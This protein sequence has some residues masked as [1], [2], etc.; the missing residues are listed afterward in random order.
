MGKCKTIV[1]K[2]IKERAIPCRGAVNTCIKKN[3]SAAN[4]RCEATINRK[5]SHTKAPLGLRSG[6]GVLAKTTDQRLRVT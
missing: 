5:S 1:L 2:I 4:V 6:F 3:S